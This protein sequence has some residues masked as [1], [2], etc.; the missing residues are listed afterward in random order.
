MRAM[1][2]KFRGLPAEMAYARAASGICASLSACLQLLGPRTVLG[3]PATSV[4]VVHAFAARWYGCVS[5]ILGPP[6]G[7]NVAEQ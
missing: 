4:T 5:A 6:V 2:E 3:S 1:L 7:L